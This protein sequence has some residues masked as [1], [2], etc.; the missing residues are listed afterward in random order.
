MMN[1]NELESNN[2]QSATE[3][4]SDPVVSPATFE[5][6][7]VFFSDEEAR[8]T[9][10]RG[11]E[12]QGF[13]ADQPPISTGPKM[14][15]R[16]Q[17]A[18]L[19]AFLLLVFSAG[20]TPTIIA[21]LYDNSNVGTVTESVTTN[22]TEQNHALVD[23]FADVHIVAKSALVFDARDDTVLYE[24]N[25]NIVRPLASV[26]KLM[27]ILLSNELVKPDTLVTVDAEAVAQDGNSG[28]G[29]GERFRFEDLSDLTIMTSANDGAYALAYA[30]GQKLDPSA[31]TTAFVKAMNIRASELGLS[32][33]YF[34]NPTGLDLSETESGA[35]GTV[36][37]IAHLMKYILKEQP[38]ALEKTTI[39]NGVI[40]NVLGESHQVA[41]TNTIVNAIPG[42]IGSKTGYTT[43][44]GGNLAVA[45]NVGVGHPVIVV[46][47]G[48]THQ[49]RL[50]DV[51]QLIKATR[52]KLGEE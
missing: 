31:P 4:T 13:L 39:L 26:T 37:D 32:D 24:K 1:E 23:P 7:E 20:A 8:E 33:T 6:E 14:P 19:V 28:L 38:D 44:A 48:S 2:D 18:V 50:T 40:Y 27:T 16:T 35:Y 41:N 3:P 49:G 22:T 17:L 30:A 42:L 10:E 47:L 51:L 52:T 5:T 25:A 12:H 36:S 43:L 11:P 45:F 46:V 21:R 34:R 9:D 29:A 15:V